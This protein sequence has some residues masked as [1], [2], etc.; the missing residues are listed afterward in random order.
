MRR[1][2]QK[3]SIDATHWKEKALKAEEDCRRFLKEKK[4]AKDERDDTVSA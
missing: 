2:L 3:L 4:A 1:Y